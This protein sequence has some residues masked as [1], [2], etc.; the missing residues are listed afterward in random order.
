MMVIL[1][2]EGNPAR[3]LQKLVQKRAS[4]AGLA[5]SERTSAHPKIRRAHPM[6]ASLSIREINLYKATVDGKLGISLQPGKEERTVMVKSLVAGGAAEVC[7]IVRGDEVLAIGGMPVSSALDAARYLRESTGSI[8]IR[9]ERGGSHV[10]SPSNDSDAYAETEE[11]DSEDF[12]DEPSEEDVV[13]EW[14]QYLDWM[15]DRIVQ[16]E[17]E[18]RECQQETA[19]ALAQSM[20]SIHEPKPPAEEDMDDPAVMQQFMEAMA[21]YAQQQQ[22]RL[23]G[24]VAEAEENREASAALLLCTTRRNELEGFLERVHL[25]TE[26]DAE[27]IEEIW[28]ELSTGGENAHDDEDEAPEEPAEASEGASATSSALHRLRENSKQLRLAQ[29]LQRARSGSSVRKATV[30]KLS[31]IAPDEVGCLIHPI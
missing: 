23:A 7:G 10:K 26:I 2:G 14:E 21:V 9:V 8:S 18:L 4:W 16:R 22:D 12:S 11:G 25:L 30:S 28:Q 3:Y 17:E 13:S 5:H 15:I 24:L 6:S 1:I 29:R 31:V 19:G 20:L 27:R